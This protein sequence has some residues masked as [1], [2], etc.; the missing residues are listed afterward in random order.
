MA[1]KL[2]GH[3]FLTVYTQS[4]VWTCGKLLKIGEVSKPHCSCHVIV[5]YI[6]YGCR[7]LAINRSRM[8]LK[9][10]SGFSATEVIVEVTTV[11]NYTIIKTQILY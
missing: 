5:L 8:C 4:K 1:S 2:I 6:K 7:S 9:D 3:T 11:N 10:V